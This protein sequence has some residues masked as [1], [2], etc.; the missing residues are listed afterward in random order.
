MNIKIKI[1]IVEIEYSEPTT[2]TGYPRI[3]SFDK[4]KDSPLNRREALMTSVAELVDKAIEAHKS[5]K[6]EF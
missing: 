1:G 3:C 5:T 4:G 2:E 6:T